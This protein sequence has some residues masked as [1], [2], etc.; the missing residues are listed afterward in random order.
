MP[1]KNSSSPVL[2]GEDVSYEIQLTFNHLTRKTYWY[3]K[4]SSDSPNGELACYGRAFELE[5][6]PQLDELFRIPLDDDFRRE[7]DRLVGELQKTLD[8]IRKYEH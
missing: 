3:I 7:C 2:R 5:E 1:I 8:L 6:R 4:A